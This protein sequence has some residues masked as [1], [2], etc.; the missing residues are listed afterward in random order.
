MVSDGRPDRPAQKV[1]A[2]KGGDVGQRKDAADRQIEATG[3]Q[4]DAHGDDDQREFG[5]LPRGFR[6]ARQRE[7]VRVLNEEKADRQDRRKNRNGV[8]APA[9]GQNFPKQFLRKIAKVE[10]LDRFHHRNL[11]SILTEGGHRGD[12]DLTTWTSLL[13][14]VEVPAAI[15][16]H[17]FL[18]DDL[19]RRVERE[20][21]LTGRLLAIAAGP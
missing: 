14:E 18:A 7:E 4:H 9:L 12:G 11:T 19:V 1:H 2:Y 13:Q 3:E 10:A 15:G 21:Q 5:Q 17:R 6:Q 8:V 16:R 20:L